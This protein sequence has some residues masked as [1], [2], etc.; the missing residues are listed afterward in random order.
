MGNSSSLC[1]PGLAVCVVRHLSFRLERNS[2]ARVFAGV[3]P[4][5]FSTKFLKLQDEDCDS[6]RTL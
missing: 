4:L 2:V 5:Q 3:I 1:W 6:V